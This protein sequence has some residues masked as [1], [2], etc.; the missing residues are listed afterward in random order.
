MAT[1]KGIS[2][3]A[4]SGMGLLVLS[5]VCI[6]AGCDPAVTVARDGAA[7]TVPIIGD[8]NQPTAAHLFAIM[9]DREGVENE[10]FVRRQ[11]AFERLLKAPDADSW[12]MI[13]LLRSARLPGTSPLAQLNRLDVARVLGSV[14]ED[15]SPALLWAVTYF[16]QDTSRATDSYT[17]TGTGGRVIQGQSVYQ[18]MRELARSALKRAIKADHGYDVGAW[19][20][21]IRARILGI[22]GGS[23]GD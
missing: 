20:T 7:S 22:P 11:A 6:A 14:R 9:E 21:A 13:I 8:Q 23:S 18:P 2:G 19:R 15:A 4:A 17:E 1:R 16:L 10:D 3:C 5:A 12:L